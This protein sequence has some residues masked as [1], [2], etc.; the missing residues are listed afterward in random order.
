MSL[1]R[2][3]LP[4]ATYLLTRRVLRRHFL[5]RPDAVLN[6]LILYALAVS[7]QR[8]GIQVHALCAMSTHLHLVVT[9]ERG[10][11]PRFL[12]FFH[13]IVALGT[14]VLRAW[15]GPVWDHEPTSVVRLMTRAAIVEE[16]AYTLANPVAAGLVRHANEWPGA[17]VLV[18]ELGGGALRAVRPDLYLDPKNPAWPPDVTLEVSLPPG[19]GADEA[20]DFRREVAEALAQEE[21]T[22]PAVQGGEG[23]LGAERAG[24]VSPYERATSVEPLRALNPTFAVGRGG[25]EAWLRAAAAVRAFRGAYRAALAEWCKGVRDVLFPEGTWWMRVCHAASV[26]PGVSNST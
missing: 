1:P 7:A 5:L 23:V 2:T 24:S 13:R 19:L 17:K 8:F 12:A 3:I 20:Q 16:I 10:V 21:A 26:R 18:D 15:E 4:G 14:K 9:D 25:K 11:L 6:N 22:A